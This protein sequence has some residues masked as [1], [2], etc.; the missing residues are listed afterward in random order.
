MP[1]QELADGGPRTPWIRLRQRAPPAG[2][3][4]RAG[5]TEGAP[6]RAPAK[7]TATR[8]DAAACDLAGDAATSCTSRGCKPSP[9]RL[10]R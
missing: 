2:I 3:H 6:P 4:R 8:G 7:S 1:P 9:D 5:L 10:R